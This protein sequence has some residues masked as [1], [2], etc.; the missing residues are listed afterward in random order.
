MKISLD[1]LKEY[2]DGDVSAQTAVEALERIGLMVEG[3]EEKDGD[4]VLEIETYSNRPDTLGH[5]GVAR[6]LAAALG[7]RLKE[8]NWPLSELAVR[9]ADLVDGQI[10][11]ETL[12]PRDCGGVVKGT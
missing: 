3:R 4:V 2:L 11:D 5:L 9:T 12:S 6:E 10:L 8:R 1:W 7:L